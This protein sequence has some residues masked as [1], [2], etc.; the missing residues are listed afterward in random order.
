MKIRLHENGWT[1]FVDDLDIRDITQEQV[2][3]ITK[4]IF[5]NMVVVFKKQS[6]TPEDEVRICE[7]FGHIENFK[8]SALRKNFLLEHGDGNII[9][10]SGAKDKDGEPGLFAHV[11]ELEWH[12]N[13]VS[14]PNRKPF[15]WLYAD[16]GSKGSVTSWLNN[17]MTYNDLPD[18]KKEEFKNIKLNVGDVLQYTEYLFEDEFSPPSIKQHRPNLVQTNPMGVTG[19][20]FS[21]NQIHFIEGMKHEDGRAFIEELRQFVEQPKYIYDHHWDDGDLVISEQLLSI[22]KRWEFP[23]IDKRV[24][25]RIAF[26]YSN[27]N[28]KDLVNK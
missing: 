19:L 12:C 5:T 17:I 15:I 8:N 20:F 21:F 10:V 9:R 3:I 28:L 24:V 13:R 22:H 1:V 2:N 25:H 7:M 4:Y 23:E 16:S 26:D 11:T 27:I 6:L 18:Q 14:D